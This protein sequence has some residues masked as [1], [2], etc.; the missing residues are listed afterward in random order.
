M[1]FSIKDFFSKY[2]QIRRKLWIW[3]HLLN[4]SLLEN[5]IFCVVCYR[6]IATSQ[7]KQ[8]F[9]SALLNCGNDLCNQAKVFSSSFYAFIYSFQLNGIKMWVFFGKKT[10]KKCTCAVM[11]RI[12][13]TFA[14]QIFL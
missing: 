11:I 10:S 2:D 1:K 6:C 5:F 4:K 3:L 9:L 13:I 14:N 8:S 12:I 7:S